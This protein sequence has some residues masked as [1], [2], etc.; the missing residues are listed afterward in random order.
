MNIYG[1]STAS[2]AHD[3]SRSFM[4]KMHIY[5]TDNF[6]PHLTVYLSEPSVDSCDIS[7]EASVGAAAS[8]AAVASHRLQME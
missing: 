7:A 8:D 5:N 3:A 1:G 4:D 6:Y 2:L